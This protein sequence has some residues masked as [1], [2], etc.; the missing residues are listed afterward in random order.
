MSENSSFTG[1]SG[2]SFK[3]C[4]TCSH[5]VPEH[6][7]YVTWCDAC[8]WN[9]KPHAAPPADTVI[10]RMHARIGNAVAKRLLA[11]MQAR[12]GE[13]MGI[14]AARVG[15]Y[16]LAGL[17][18]LGTIALA[19]G[20][21]LLIVNGWP[22]VIS[23]VFGVLL[24]LLT[25]VL[26]PR[27]GRMPKEYATRESYPALYALCDR[28]A[29]AVGTRRADAILF[30]HQLNASI[31]R[32]GVRG[33]TL[34][35]IGLPLFHILDAQGKVAL[36]AHEFAHTANG[37]SVR[38]IFVGGA[39]HTLEA[40]YRFLMQTAA[41]Q[42]EGGLTALLMMVARL[43]MR[44]AAGI[45]WIYLA[46]LHRLLGHDSQRAEYRADYL[47]A[48]VAGP[49]ASLS[50]L[51]TLH[52]GYIVEYAVQRTAMNLAES[53]FDELTAQVAAIPPREWQRLDRSAAMAESRLDYTHP[54]TA[55]RIAFIESLPI[56]APA[57]TISSADLSAL[58]AEIAPVHAHAQRTAVTEY[59]AAI[60]M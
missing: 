51:R 60:G 59:H 49:T 57:V 8:G 22:H 58:N 2:D 23:I 54:P 41:E 26:A 53:L 21:I 43:L 20:A 1:A 44:A 28:V 16:G 11:D 47:A 40:S 5:A 15:A 32:V 4:P 45:I 31:A 6:A 3:K 37:D 55:L 46:A 12:A 10:S 13:R 29:D 27:L 52:L 34:L 48:R 36:L 38:S 25:W 14:S 35:V 9:V 33:R 56:T 24:L 50:A 19:A 30:D 42:T 17:V 7:G 39:V 18:Y